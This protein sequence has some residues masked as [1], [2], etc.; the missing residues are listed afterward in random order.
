[1]P[2]A[3]EYKEEGNICFKATDYV[4]A[5]DNY[6]KA[7]EANPTSHVFYN[8]RAGAYHALKRYD[9]AIADGKKSLSIQANAKAH[10][11][12]GAA[13]W[14][15]GRLELA[16]SSYEMALVEA[17]GDRTASQNIA[18]LK[19]RISGR[20]APQQ[21]GRQQAPAPQGPGDMVALVLDSVVVITV[22]AQLL[23]GLL[24]PQLAPMVWQLTLVA[25]AARCVLLLRAAGALQPSM[26][27]LKALP[28]IFGG[29]YLLLCIALLFISQSPLPTIGGALAIYC[30]VDAATQ[31]RALLEP[32][33][34]E[35][36]RPQ[37]DKVVANKLSILANATVC[38]V[39]ALLMAPLM[40]GISIMLVMFQLLRARYKT[41]QVTR[42]TF[43]QLGQMAGK[44][45]Y[46]PRCPPIIGNAFTSLKGILLKLVA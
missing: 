30:V 13:Q 24:A 42:L 25:M 9:E 18:I 19:Q 5:L 10:S 4:G 8:N 14:E 32:H 36:L 23:L 12:I 29:Q 28:S 17:P 35:S 11:R 16:L 7:I 45:F 41:D 40:G 22:V 39:G 44:V 26:E 15:M 37:M 33:I 1:M 46:H 43:G 31:Q 6:T 21:Q 27:S 2:T 38:E 3:E 20:S 34:P